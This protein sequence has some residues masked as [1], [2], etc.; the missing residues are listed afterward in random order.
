MVSIILRGFTMWLTFAI[1]LPLR[2]A[3]S[4]V[5]VHATEGDKVGK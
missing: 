3:V 5:I 4:G 1:V 2:G